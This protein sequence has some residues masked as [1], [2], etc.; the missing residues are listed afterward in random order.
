MPDLVIRGGAVVDGTGRRPPVTADVAVTGDRIVEVGRVSGR[1]RREID[2]SGLL[3]T[4]G[5]VDLHTHFDG[6]ATWDPVLAPSSVHG[7]TT[8]AMGNC[9]VGFAPARPDTHEWLIGLLE[10]VEDI[11]GTA[12]AEGLRWDWESFPEYLDSLDAMSRTIDVA[13]HLPHS[14]LRTYVMGERGADPHEHPDDDELAQITQLTT[15]ALEAGALGF[16]T[17]R[18]EVHRTNQGKRL[19]TLCAGEAELLAIAAALRGHGRGVIQIVSD[20]YLTPDD[21]FADTELSLIAAMARAAGRPVSITVQQNRT[22]PERWRYVFDQLSRWNREGMD[23]KAQVA[24]RPIGVLLGLD[25]TT[26]PFARCAS[27]REISDHPAPTLARVM[28]DPDRRLRIL[29]EHKTLVERLPQGLGRDIASAFDAM[30]MLADPVNYDFDRRDSIGARADRDGLDAAAVVYDTLLAADGQ[31][32]VYLAL[33]N[34]VH[35]NLDVVREM[36]TAPFALHGLSD[37][38]AHCGTV[39]DASTAT[40]YLSMWGRDRPIPEL[41]IEAVI[42]QITGRPARHAGWSDRG[43]VA[44]GALADI[45]VIDLERLECRRPHITRDLPAGG[46]RLVQDADGYRWT[47]KS[48][49]PTFIDGVPT[50]ARPGRLVRGSGSGG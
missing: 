22:A 13:A 41:P 8:V 21:A 34:F 2:A 5:F 49:R 19:G 37:A 33:A 27:F 23:V 28:A 25:A 44:P 43:T 10:G 31:Q 18:T 45:N 4:P 48:G 42:H 29:D 3:V 46:R 26:N 15:Q 39:C 7:V 47:I 24:P 38:G 50:G 40:S 9:G 14:A 32:L 1:G 12:L 6:Q 30:F 11:P 20:L 36:I 17:S 35:G 16:A